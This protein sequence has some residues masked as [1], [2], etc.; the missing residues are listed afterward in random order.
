[1]EY[2]VLGLVSVWQL[3]PYTISLD[4]PILVLK[5]LSVT[6]M[7]VNSSLTWFEGMNI[8]SSQIVLID[9]C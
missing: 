9:Y 7:W 5:I 3:L 1:M 4:F 6:D 8:N 2:L